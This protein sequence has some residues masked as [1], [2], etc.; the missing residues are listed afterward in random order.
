M[1]SAKFAPWLLPGLWQSG[2]GYGQKKAAGGGGF[3]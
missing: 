1:C 3:G 2:L